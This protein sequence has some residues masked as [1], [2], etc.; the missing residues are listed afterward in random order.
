MKHR[1]LNTTEWNRMSIDSLFEDGV[2][3]DWR[4]FAIA[5]KQDRKLASETMKVVSYHQ[6]RGSSAFAR[7][8]V[9][10]FY[11]TDDLGLE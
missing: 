6:E 9:R 11:G 5:L 10:H 7:V 3:D 1:N 4:E 2:I 8:L